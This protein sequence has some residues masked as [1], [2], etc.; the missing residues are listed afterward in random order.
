MIS[1]FRAISILTQNPLNHLCIDM[2]LS[3]ENGQ[4]VDTSDLIRKLEDNV[5][6][7]TIREVMDSDG[8]I[9]LNLRDYLQEA[10]DPE[11]SIN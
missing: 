1:L 9:A 6:L 4:S 11:S 10:R 8:D 3:R 7:R 5:V 2:L